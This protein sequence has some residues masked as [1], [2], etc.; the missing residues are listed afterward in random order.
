MS[1]SCLIWWQKQLELV[2]N[3]EIIT[4]F[5]VFSFTLAPFPHR[6]LD[7]SIMFY[8]VLG[9]VTAIARTVGH[10][11]KSAEVM[12]LVNNL[13]KAPE[14]AATMQEFGKEMIKVFYFQIFWQVINL[15][16]IISWVINF[17]LLSIF[18]FF[19]IFK[20]HI[21]RCYWSTPSSVFMGLVY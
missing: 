10:L 11:N 4:L 9:W 13:M 1:S 21:P 20:F 12:K 5:F 18:F 6:P 19:R 3:W 16:L 2:F 7:F 15:K 8:L 14:L 17:K